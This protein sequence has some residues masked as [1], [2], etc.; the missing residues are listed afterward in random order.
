MKSRVVLLAD[1][2][3]RRL[4]PD[5]GDGRD[6]SLVVNNILD[7]KINATG[8]V[9]LTASAAT[10]VVTDE[11]A[12]FDSVILLMPTTSNASLEQGNGTIFVSSRGKQTFTITHANNS[13]A[14]R[15]YRYIVIG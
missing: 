10:T 4:P 8:T 1:V 5:G 9:T 15:T 7:G 11:R 13:Q 14:D 6:V 12:G 3:F 2:N